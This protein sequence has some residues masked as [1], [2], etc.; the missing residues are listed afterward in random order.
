MMNFKV[1]IGD[2]VPFE[3]I[4]GDNFLEEYLIAA[5]LSD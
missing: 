3:G 4:G 2:F 1:N 5:K